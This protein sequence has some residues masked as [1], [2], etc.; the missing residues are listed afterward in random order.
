MKLYHWLIIVLLQMAFVAFGLWLYHILLGGTGMEP[1]L[2]ITLWAAI[3][4]I[5]FVVFSLIGMKN[6]DGKIGELENSNDKIVRKYEEIEEKSNE[7]I[8]SLSDSRKKIVEEAEIEIKNI[9][10]NSRQIQ[11]YYQI[12]SSIESEPNPE[13]RIIMFT[14]LLSKPEPPEGI[15]NSYIFIKRG[16]CYMQL[17]LFD[18]AKT[19]YEL[20][21]DYAQKFNKS[22]AY[23]CIADYYV[24]TQ[25]IPKSIEYYRK[26]ISEAPSALLYSDLGNSLNKNKAFKEADECYDKALAMNPELAGVYYNKSLMMHENI[27]NPSPADYAQMVSY[28]EKAI[29]INPMFIPAY[30]NKANLFREQGKEADAVE[31]LNQ[32]LNPMFNDEIVNAI[33]QRGIANR[34]TNN[35]PKALNDFCTVL[36]HRPHNVQNL[37]NLAL[38]YLGMGYLR[39]AGYYAQ[40]GLRE[41]NEQDNHTCDGDLFQVQQTVMALLRSPYEKPEQSNHKQQ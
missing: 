2:A 14:D 35:H 24:R 28:L 29:A 6:I 31:A 33:L 12:I 27:D 10:K 40:L 30:I 18:K 26:A 4:T 8:H 36:L 7:L 32:V 5:V 21:L 20:S 39:E 1:G 19:D 15:D 13:R 23:A 22:S 37:S 17:G 3:I 11:R 38:T 34:L 41:A 9:T 25:D 16:L